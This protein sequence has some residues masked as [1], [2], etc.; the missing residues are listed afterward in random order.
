MHLDKSTP[1]FRN[2][3]IKSCFSPFPLGFAELM[4]CQTMQKIP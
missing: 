3:M 1:E 2:T 4:T